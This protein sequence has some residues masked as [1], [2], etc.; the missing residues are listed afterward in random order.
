MGIE[1]TPGLNGDRSQWSDE[2]YG[3]LKN[4]LN[5]FIPL[6]RFVGIS[7]IDFLCKVQPY[8][9]IFLIILDL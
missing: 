5:Q 2:D 8:K 4:A 9:V 7:P 6:I 1:Q 3:A